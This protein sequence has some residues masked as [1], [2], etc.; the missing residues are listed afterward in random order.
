[1]K[2]VVEYRRLLMVYSRSGMEL[3]LVRDLSS[4]TG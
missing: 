1:M 3:K 4:R 2:K